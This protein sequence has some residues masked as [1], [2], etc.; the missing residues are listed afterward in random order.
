MP[1]FK[2]KKAKSSQWDNNGET[3]ALGSSPATREKFQKGFGQIP[4]P[5]RDTAAAIRSKFKSFSENLFSLS[6]DEKKK[7]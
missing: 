4:A 7:K 6:E 3:D 5:I 1:D 2:V